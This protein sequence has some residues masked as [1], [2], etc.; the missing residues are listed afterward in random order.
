MIK[1][2]LKTLYRYLTYEVD[3]NFAL[4]YLN[5]NFIHNICIETAK[6]VIMILIIPDAIF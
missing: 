3:I 6:Q 2:V 5:V 1:N 4:I